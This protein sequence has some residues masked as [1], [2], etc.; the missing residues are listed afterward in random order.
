MLLK[1]SRTR[2]AAVLFPVV[3]SSPVM[4]YPVIH[5]ASTCSTTRPS[6]RRTTCW[7][8][9]SC[10]GA[11]CWS[12]GGRERCCASSMATARQQPPVKEMT[13]KYCGGQPVHG[14]GP[15]V[16]CTEHHI[17]SLEHHILCL[18]FLA[19]EGCPSYPSC[20]PWTSPSYRASQQTTQT[21]PAPVLYR[22]SK[23]MAPAHC[24]RA[25]SADCLAYVSVVEA[26]IQRNNI[27]QT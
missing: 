6:S 4:N 10:S 23:V 8:C 12:T 22:S 17:L 9:S 27:R 15:P 19:G 5:R 13:G 20:R 11:T 24:F 21:L 2:C 26:F 1:S 3:P 14:N 7:R 25:L 16:P 18:G